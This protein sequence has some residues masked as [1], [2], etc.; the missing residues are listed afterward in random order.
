[1]G[2]LHLTSPLWNLI[3][4]LKVSDIMQIFLGQHFATIFFCGTL[5][6]TIN[7][8]I[9][10]HIAPALLCERYAIIIS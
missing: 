5:Y 6:N 8:P 4:L 9:L 7:L 10:L 1:M 2:D 3:I